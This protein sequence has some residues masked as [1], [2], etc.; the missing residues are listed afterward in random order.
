MTIV[1]AS[2]ITPDGL[3][4]LLDRAGLSTRN[5]SVRHCETGG[6]N[7]LYRIGAGDEFYA[8]KQYK[9]CGSDKRDRLGAEWSFLSAVTR[10]FPDAP[11]PAPLAIDRGNGFALYGF[12]DGR[13]L[14][15]QEIEREH[16]E[17]FARFFRMLNTS[18]MKAQASSLPEASEAAFSMQGHFDI[19]LARLDRLRRHDPGD[20]MIG[21]LDRAAELVYRTLQDSGME[22]RADLPME[23]R[24]VSPS[25]F[26]FHNA[27]LGEEGNL[28]FIDFEYAGWDDP[29][30]LCADFFFQPQIPLDD[31]HY[32]FFAGECL[33]YLPEGAR[34][35]HRRRV[36]LLRPL[37]GLRWCCIILN[38]FDPA[39][40]EKHG[41]APTD[42]ALEK[43]RGERFESGQRLLGRLERMIE[44][45]PAL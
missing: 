12:I 24:C 17:Q 40:A 41:F 14:G 11:V 37:F 34:E 32:D 20:G 19:L 29:A 31:R 27:L 38:P 6:N 35:R 26:G 3:E 42:P 18:G 2:P 4:T 44:R 10:E 43:I 28:A 9:S 30:K 39:W 15:A 21:G 16:I 13:K 7:V 22:L 5:I 36:E 23:E 33:S 8:L 25:D 45:S 1:D